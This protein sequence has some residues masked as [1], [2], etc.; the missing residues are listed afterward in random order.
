VNVKN[1]ITIRIA[2]VVLFLCACP[3]LG[4][5]NFKDGLTHNINYTIYDYVYVDYKAPLMFTTV[6][7]LPGGS[8]SWPYSIIG[9]NNS[10]INVCG[11]YICILESNDFSQADI[12]GGAIDNLYSYDSSPVNISGGS[13]KYLRSFGSSQLNITGGSMTYLQS[14]GSSEV[15]ISSGSIKNLWTYVSSQVDIY[16]GSVGDLV[17]WDQSMIQIFGS[18]FAV[19]GEPFGYGELTSILG[20]MY[21]DEPFRHLSGTLLSGELIDGDF[22]IGNDARIILIPEPAT[23]ALISIG[24]L[25]LRKRYDRR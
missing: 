16:A 15:N 5:I 22:R 21:Y 9:F 23:M 18:D 7:W 6:N 8:M 10:M 25:F 19:D 14:F 12:S 2:V 20:G 4:D 1:V 11:G 3:A 24:M 17:L 13:V